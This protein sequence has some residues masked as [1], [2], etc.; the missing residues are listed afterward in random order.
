MVRV[1]QQY[2][3]RCSTEDRWYYK[4]IMQGDAITCP[5]DDT[6]TVDT[7]LTKVL[8]SVINTNDINVDLSHNIYRS[9]QIIRIH[10]SN[11]DVGTA[12]E[13]I[14]DVG[15]FYNWT[16]GDPFNL[17]VTTNNIEDGITGLGARKIRVF[18]LDSNYNSITEDISILGN[19]TVYSTNQFH[20]VFETHVLETG[21]FHGSNYNNIDTGVSGSGLVL[22]RIG[23]D[24]GT[25][26]TSDYGVATSQQSTYTVPAGKTAYITRIGASIDTNKT[27]DI[28]LYKVSG[29]DTT[30]YQPRELMWRLDGFGDHFILNLKSFIKIPEK[31]DIW[32]RAK[33]SASAVIT[34]DYDLYLVDQ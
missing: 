15:G 26:D 7:N 12:L 22:S 8:S 25:I 4:W 19:S 31:S 11:S 2:K 14:W 23:G 18:G 29:I 34:V 17:Q 10:A 16:S 28:F 3:I 20:R 24:G 30:P 5:I 9:D 13:D 21:T 33:A 1:Y 6:H 27:A 32:F